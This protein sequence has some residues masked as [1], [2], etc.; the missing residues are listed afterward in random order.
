MNT[1]PLSTTGISV[2]EF[3]FGTVSLGLPYGIGV[4]NESDM[5]SEA[6]SI[7]LLQDALSRGVN[8]LDTALAYGKSEAIVGK[9]LSGCRDKAIRHCARGGQRDIGNHR[10]HRADFSTARPLS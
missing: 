5:P 7:A 8:F 4:S 6:D 10:A 3:F 2:S 9:A 1:K